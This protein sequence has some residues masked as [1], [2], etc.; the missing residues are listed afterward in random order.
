MVSILRNSFLL[1]VFNL[2]LVSNV[3]AENSTK[4]AAEKVIQE[5]VDSI[6]EN[7][8]TNKVKYEN[9]P[10]DFYS[11]LDS[12]LGKIVDEEGLV[13]GVMTARFLKTATPNQVLLFTEKFKLS[14]FKL[15]GNG[16]LEYTNERFNIVSSRIN[17]SGSRASVNAELITTKNIRYP[18]QYSM[19]YNGET[20]KIR[21]VIV[22]GINFGKLYRDQFLSAMRQNN[23]DLDKTIAEW[24]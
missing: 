3:Y 20:W 11:Y 10:Q 15:Y 24:K 8:K 5:S 7:I 14:L 6:L 12:S 22:N 18:I 16:L 9:N 23:N 2:L 21:N 19:V 13:R 17:Q 4:I 1:F